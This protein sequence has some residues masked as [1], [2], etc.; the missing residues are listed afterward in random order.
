[1][2][3]TPAVTEELFTPKV[4]G[5]MVDKSPQGLATW[6]AEGR[7]PRFVKLGGRVYYRASDVAAWLD[8]NTVNP[9]RP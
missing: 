8:A 5:P 2:S 4:F 9:A 7:G 1:M 3:D 6:R